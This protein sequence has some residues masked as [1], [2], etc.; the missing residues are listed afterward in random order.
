M[1]L[2]EEY[3]DLK[4]VLAVSGGP[5]SMAL[6][7]LCYKQGMAFEVVHVNYH[8]RETANRDQNIVESY[9]K[10]R[11]IK[12]HVFDALDLEGNF[13][14]A[15]REYRYEKCRSVIH[16]SHADGMM[17]AH[18]KDDD[19]ETYLFQKQRHSC[20]TWFGLK[21]EIEMKGVR[22]VRP[23]LSLSK[24]NLMDYCESNHISYGLDESNLS[25]DYTRNQ[26]RSVIEKMTNDQIKALHD[27]KNT[28]NHERQTYLKRYA[29]QLA[30]LSFSEKEYLELSKEWP[31]FLM[32]WLI[33][34]GAK[35]ALSNAYLEELDRQLIEAQS[36][37]HPLNKTLRLIKQY[38][39][40]RLVPKVEDYAISI[41]LKETMIEPIRFQYERFDGSQKFMCKTSDFPLMIRNYRQVSK[42]LD[43]SIR[44]ACQRWFIKHKIPLEQRE[45]WPLVFNASNELIYISHHKQ[46]LGVST[47]T[48][49]C[50]M[51]K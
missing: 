39:M 43:P 5:D 4:W 7:D 8:K 14:M 1:T 21:T 49:E 41:Q 50:Y 10:E 45:S 17:V 35:P 40:I 3:Q 22:L 47:D 13:Q 30:Q 36:V 15:A 2:L 24:K 12:I 28:L 29:S 9:C 33:Q 6:L 51:I 27:E 23:L 26:I 42:D 18:H 48:I 20:V 19:L 32:H 11:S 25:L 46:Q 34:Q 31:L 38:K 37:V 16:S 44:S